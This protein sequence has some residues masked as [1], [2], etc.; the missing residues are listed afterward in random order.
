MT[1]VQTCALP[2]CGLLLGQNEKLEVMVKKVQRVL[3]VRLTDIN[4]YSELSKNAF[5]HWKQKFNS[6]KN[7]E[8]FTKILLN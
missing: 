5:E 2:I 3:S 4:A 6:E 7:Y 1:G 8:Q